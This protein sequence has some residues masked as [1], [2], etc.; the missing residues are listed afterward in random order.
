MTT[1]IDWQTIRDLLRQHTQ[2]LQSVVTLEAVGDS[3]LPMVPSGS[4]LRVR[5][6][7]VSHIRPG[8]I[9]VFGDRSLMAHRCILRLGRRVYERGDNCPIAFPG[10]KQC[11]GTVVGRVETVS[12][13]NARSVEVGRPAYRLCG[14]IIALFTLCLLPLSTF[15]RLWKRD[16][17]QAVDRDGVLERFFY[18]LISTTYRWTTTYENYCQRRQGG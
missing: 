11:R 3:M 6:C 5:C 14:R 15:R 7:D 1:S 8:D 17:A 16:D 4:S 9:V 10:L 12:P 2:S 18:L 13:P